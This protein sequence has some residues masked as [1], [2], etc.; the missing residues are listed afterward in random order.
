M[1]GRQP[2]SGDAAARIQ[3]LDVAALGAGRE[4]A[5]VAALQEDSSVVR[6]H[7]I[8]LAARH[9]PPERLGAFVADHDDAVL[10]NAA[11]SALERQGP[12]AVP[13][14]VG[15]AASPDT[16]VAMFA[17][18]VL[19][20]IADPST[21]SVLLPL[22][23][24]ADPNIGQAAIEA[25]GNLRAREAVPSLLAA[26]SAEAWLQF[27]AIAA[28]GE[29]GDERAIR[30]LLDL[31]TD[32]LLGES[33]VEALGKIGG[34]EALPRMIALLIE[35]DRLPL[36]DHLLRAIADVVRRHVVESAVLAP[37]EAAV[38]STPALGLAGYLR[39]LLGSSDLGLAQAAATVVLASSTMV[40]YPS[41]LVR[42]DEPEIASVLLALAGRYP[43]AVRDSSGLL[44]RHED[45][46]VRRGVL[47]LGIFA[48]DAASELQR[49]LD[50]ADVRIRLSACEAL[51][52]RR[53]SSAAAALVTRL[54]RGDVTERAAAAEALARLP[55]AALLALGPCLAA[56]EEHEL[57]RTA[58][59]VL[60]RARS[61]LFID[62]VLGWLSAEAGELRRAALRVVANL[63]DGALGEHLNLALDDPDKHVVID[64]VELIVRRACDG[65]VERLMPLLRRGADIR[66]HVIRGLGRLHAAAATTPLKILYPMVSANE[67]TEILVALIRIGG[68]DI[69]PFLS[70]CLQ[71][72]AP[73]IRRLAAD[74][75][76][77]HA[78]VHELALL[79]HLA[80]DRDWSIRNHAGW[81]LGRLGL[82]ESRDTLLTLARDVEPVVA[83]TAR[84]ALGKLPA[85]RGQTRILT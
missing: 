7:A 71:E 68:A 64:A 51:G 76:A 79:T 5:I 25:L 26:L 57:V 27:A 38:G 20:R 50:D 74:G 1:S 18:Q 66:Y 24:H 82:G 44:L 28:L 42:M 37:I 78:G 59:G 8:A 35:H 16:E 11:L 73:D 31:A 41:M 61:S 6:E 32:E 48:A 77:R 67:R 13:F 80:S 43:Q 75:L 85:E 49:C 33:A 15:L 55:G 30:P 58:L 9:L 56:G 12:Y 72:S 10:R 4:S 14:L 60:E 22:V 29:I 3:A 70:Q 34:V 69:V 23:E 21:V 83:R 19:A 62:E 84:L 36:R 65:A 53:D 63:P 54:R 46:R 52:R 81:G 40:L 2:R 47:A 39:T 45:V 17:V